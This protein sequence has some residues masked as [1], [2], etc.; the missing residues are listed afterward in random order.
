MFHIINTILVWSF[1]RITFLT[2]ALKKQQI[3]KN[4]NAIAVF[5]AL[6][7]LTHPIQTQAVTYITQRFASLATFFY[8]LSA[9]AYIR[10]RLYGIGFRAVFVLAVSVLAAVCAMKTKEISF[11][12][13]FMIALA[14]LAF[15]TGPLGR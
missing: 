4:R 13:P 15:F 9:V 11:T 10:A 7:F 3:T 5:A 12:L 2:P 6:I 8:L 1:I 14:E